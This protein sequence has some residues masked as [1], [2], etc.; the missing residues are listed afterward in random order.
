MTQGGGG[1]PHTTPNP[2]KALEASFPLLKF[3]CFLHNHV[4]N[5][6]PRFLSTYVQALF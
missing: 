4:A 1:I 5:N 2:I 3:V 6:R